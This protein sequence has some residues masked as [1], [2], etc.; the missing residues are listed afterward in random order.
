MSQGLGGE[1]LVNVRNL[2]ADAG[3]LTSII[4][5]FKA[6][7]GAFRDAIG[8]GTGRITYI[9]TG[10]VNNDGVPDI[11]ASLGPITAEGPIYPNIIIPRDGSTKEVIGHTFESLP[12]GR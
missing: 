9:S 8:G 1:T 2:N 10:D 5:S 11:V 4:L 7:G 12:N 3:T 6:A